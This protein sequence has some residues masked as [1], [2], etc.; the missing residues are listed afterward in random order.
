MRLAS[1]DRMSTLPLTPYRQIPISD[2]LQPGQ[3]VLL[4]STGGL[5][6]VR[7]WLVNPLDGGCSYAQADGATVRYLYDGWHIA[8]TSDVGEHHITIRSHLDV[9]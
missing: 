2:R 8:V 5:G 3:R 4:H 1:G 9:I 7:G 6:T